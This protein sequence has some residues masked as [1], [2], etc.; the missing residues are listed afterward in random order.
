[1]RFSIYPPNSNPPPPPPPSERAASTWIPKPERSRLLSSTPSV[2]GYTFINFGQPVPT[3]LASH[4]FL[5]SLV[6]AGLPTK[7]AAQAEL[8][9]A[10]GIRIRTKTMESILASTVDQSSYPPIQPSKVLPFRK[11]PH[12]APSKY[13]ILDAHTRI[14]VRLL[15]EA[16]R[17]RQERTERM[18]D[19][20]I[21]ACLIQGEIIVA[22]LLF[23]MLIKDW[24]LRSALKNQCANNPLSEPSKPPTAPPFYPT[25]QTYWS[26]LE[27]INHTLTTRKDPQDPLFR[28]ALQALANLAFAVDTGLFP[29][30]FMGSLIKALYSVPKSDARVYIGSP[31]KARLNAYEYI[32][33]VLMRL[34][35][36]AGG[37]RDKQMDLVA[38]RKFNS[39]AFN[40]LLYY[41]VYRRM[42]KAHASDLLEA[43][44][45]K[46]FGITVHSAN[47]LL[48]CSTLLRDDSI[49][50]DRRCP[51]HTA[52]SAPIALPPTPH[53]NL[54]LTRWAH[55]VDVLKLEHALQYP[56][57]PVIHTPATPNSYTVTGL[58][59]H[60][61]ATNRGHII[62]E[63]LYEIIPE[64]NL[65]DE[66]GSRVTIEERGRCTV[67]YGPYFFTTVLNALV[68]GGR[69]RY[70]EQVWRLAVA[71]E[72]ASWVDRTEPW[73]LPIHAYTCM[74][75]LYSEE[76]S[77]GKVTAS[78]SRNRSNRRSASAMVMG[79]QVFR[80]VQFRCRFLESVEGRDV[81]SQVPP[82]LQK[83]TPDE[84]YFN[85]LLD[86]YGS[87]A[88]GYARPMK[89]RRGY[90]RWLEKITG[91]RFARSGVTTDYWHPMLAEIIPEMD[92]YGY[93]VP[94]GLRF[95]LVGR[96][97]NV[98]IGGSEPWQATRP[99][100]LPLRR[101]LQYIPVLKTRGLPV[102]RGRPRRRD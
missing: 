72:K 70:A 12:N 74:L 2:N 23:I 46:R 54:P 52:D 57:D 25:R 11:A 58:I 29:S 99:G 78:S 91:N 87:R 19:V 42:S 40:A 18:Y 90:W 65:V 92:K 21:N 60:L 4:S 10:D 81:L 102:P 8:M 88:L 82:A 97:S 66:D 41:C 95:L 1:M 28:N 64:L 17:R 33:E 13:P 100:P 9:M 31:P 35:D 6:N 89:N 98:D 63:K 69:I 16:R 59:T 49:R 3:R 71:A 62:A 76:G 73:F 86:L 84:R 56:S 27:R 77:P 79:K 96:I 50:V 30:R 7:A 45:K 80:T 85:A 48:R 55:I 61:T 22:S 67:S 36:D 44:K 94:E 20:V 5:H 39:H 68:K 75:Q 38:G 15:E 37:K 14:A 53:P 34:A 47:L 26:L 24:Q 93:K 83:F 32:H 101:S 43:M 51:A